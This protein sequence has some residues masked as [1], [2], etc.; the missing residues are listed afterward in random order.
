MKRLPQYNF[1][2]SNA[3]NIKH[4]EMPGIYRKCFIMLRLTSADG[5]ANSVQECEAME[6]PVVHNQSEYGFKWSSVDDVVN[7]IN[8]AS[9]LCGRR[10]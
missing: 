3:L 10:A 9:R 2:L 8:R 4:E 1:I 6:I 5:N 7:H